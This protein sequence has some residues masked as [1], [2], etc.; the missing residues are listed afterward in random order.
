MSDKTCRRL[1][2]E[3][4]QRKGRK[5]QIEKDLAKAQKKKRKTELSLKMNEAAQIIIHEIAK[6]TQDKLQIHISDLVSFGLA[7]VFTPAPL[8]EVDFVS[9]RGKIEADMFFLDDNANRIDPM[10]SSGGG[11]VDIASLSLRLSLS[12]L[13]R[14]ATRPIMILDEPLKFLKGDRLPIKGARMIKEFSKQ[15]NQQIIM[16]SHDPELVEQADNIIN[17]SL[18]DRKSIIKQEK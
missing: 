16:V 18:V 15:L 14:P 7:S 17:V 3:L 13:E 10:A 11:A 6:K 5:V 12:S 4:E 1:R 2:A 9:R 8:F